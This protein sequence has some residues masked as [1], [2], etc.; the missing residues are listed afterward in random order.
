LAALGVFAK[1]DE[2]TDAVRATIENNALDLVY[3]RGSPKQMLS[4][5]TARV[6]RPQWTLPDWM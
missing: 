2:R 3:Y 1:S 4:A 5:Y 6:G